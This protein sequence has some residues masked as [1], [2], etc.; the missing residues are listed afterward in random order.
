MVFSKLKE[1]WWL[2][3]GHISEVIILCIAL[4]KLNSGSIH[5]NY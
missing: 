5:G 4:L 1:S 3:E 2:S